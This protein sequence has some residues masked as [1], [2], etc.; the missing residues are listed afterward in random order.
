MQISHYSTFYDLGLAV[1]GDL[2]IAISLAIAG[3]LVRSYLHS[4]LSDYPNADEIICKSL[5]SLDYIRE[6]P[7]N[8]RQYVLGAL[9]LSTE[10]AFGISCGVL[11]VSLVATFFLREM[12]RSMSEN[13]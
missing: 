8:V 4:R 5:E 10:K 1:A 6:L 7:P 9:T 2:G 11:I 3:A 13:F 12:P